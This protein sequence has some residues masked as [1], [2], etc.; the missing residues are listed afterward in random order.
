MNT[1]ETPNH[2]EKMTYL[3]DFGYMCWD[4]RFLDK[5]VIKDKCHCPDLVKKYCLALCDMLTWNVDESIVSNFIKIAKDD[6]K[7]SLFNK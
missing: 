1:N 5:A 3:H 7:N 6:I 4:D 2:F